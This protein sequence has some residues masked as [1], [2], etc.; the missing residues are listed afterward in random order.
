MVRCQYS[1]TLLFLHLF[2]SLLRLVFL[3]VVPKVTGPVTAFLALGL[4]L[5]LHRVGDVRL[6]PKVQN[7]AL[8]AQTDVRACSHFHAVM[9]LTK[10]N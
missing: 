7:Q 6:L 3:P 9:T 8:G 10:S 1:H 2:K 4:D 5:I